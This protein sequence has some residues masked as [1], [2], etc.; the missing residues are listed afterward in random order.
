MQHTISLLAHRTMQVQAQYIL[1]DG[2][3]PILLLIF[4]VRHHAVACRHG[5]DVVIRHSP[6]QNEIF[7]LCCHGHLR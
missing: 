7:N 3:A 6:L 2:F 1:A 4:L 5:G